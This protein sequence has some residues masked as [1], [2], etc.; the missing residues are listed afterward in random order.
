MEIVNFEIKKHPNGDILFV[1]SRKD[2]RSGLH[3]RDPDD[4]LQGGKL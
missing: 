2:R 3:F 1:K 4:L